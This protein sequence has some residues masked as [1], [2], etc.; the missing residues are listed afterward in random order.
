MKVERAI[1][2]P[3]RDKMAY[4]LGNLA[5]GVA[6]QIL[7]TY[8]VFYSTAI[9]RLPGRFISMVMGYVSD[10][11]RSKRLGRWHPY[12]VAGAAGIALTNYL[13]WNIA[14][15]LSPVAKLVLI[16]VHILFFKTFMTVYDPVSGGKLQGPYRR[17]ERKWYHLVLGA[18]QD[19]DGGK[20]LQVPRRPRLRPLLFLHCYTTSPKDE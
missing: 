3:L 5:T 13:I 14:P 1:T 4:G 9:L 10:M 16:T 15:V 6:M 2:V 18:G 11:T 20:P 12:L 17:T 19:R 8:L 7:G